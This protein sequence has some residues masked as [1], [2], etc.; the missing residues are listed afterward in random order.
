MPFL[1]YCQEVT[2]GQW[3]SK[4]GDEQD[5]G[6]AGM[7]EA[8]AAPSQTPHHAKAAPKIKF[9]G[10]LAYLNSLSKEEQVKARKRIAQER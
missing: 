5:Q 7:G 6:P 3:L 2:T 4:L 1:M 8:A 10:E 9:E